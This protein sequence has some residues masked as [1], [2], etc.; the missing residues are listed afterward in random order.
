MKNNFKI[1]IP[2][3]KNSQR[4]SSKNTKILCGKPLIS[5]TIEYSINHFNANDI[6]VNTD[7]E[8]I[9]EI[10]KKYNINIYER[11][12][13]LATN[14]TKISDVL[15]DQ[16]NYFIKEDIYFEHIILLQPTNPFRDNYNINDIINYY[17]NNNIKSLMSVSQINRKIGKISEDKFIPINY[18]FGQR[19]QNICK[20]FKRDHRDS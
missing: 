1:I 5:Y 15:I 13:S 3:R 4:L 2:A 14:T 12:P 19:S 6:W 7:D 10:A 20:H 11:K 16:C 18:K 17:L 8:K 9:L